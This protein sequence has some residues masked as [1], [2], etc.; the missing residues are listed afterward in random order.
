[1]AMA[2]ETE[3]RDA[4]S[5]T[6]SGIGLF[7]ESEE[8]VSRNPY[9]VH[10]WLHYLAAA[11]DSPRSTRYALYERAVAAL[12]RSY[13][14]WKLYLD[15]FLDHEA[16]GRRLDADGNEQLIALYE[17][18]L[19]QLST[20]PRL[21]LDYLAHLQQLQRVT[22]S[23]RVLDRA[24]RALP[25]TQHARVW[26][27]FVAFVR[28]IRGVPRTVR[29]VYRRYLMLEPAKREE[30]VDYLCETEQWRDA[31]TQ[32][33]VLL[34]Q[35][36]SFPT[37]KTRHA[38]WMQ[39]CDMV[40]QHP[41]DVDPS[42]D[43]D[44]LLRSG[45]AQFSDEVGRLWCALATYY[46]RL[47]L[48][49]A[50]RDVYEEAITAVL[51]VR[52]FS[53][54]FDAY[55]QFVE[56]MLTTEMELA[57][58]ERTGGDEKEQED[59]EKEEEEENHQVQVDR[60]LKIYEDVADRRPLLLNSVLLRQNPNNVREW[61]KRVTLLSADASRV[62]RTY[63]ETVQAVDPQKSGGRLATL[64]IEF[65][66]FYE[67]RQRLGD[68]RAVLQRATDVAFRN[69]QELASIH[70]AWAEMELRAENFD[71]A[72]EIVRAACRAPDARRLRGVSMQQQTA[73]DKLHRC[74]KLWTLRLDL[75]ESLGD[76]ASTRAAY[77]DAFDL[78]LIT[79]QMVLNYAAYL[80]ENKYFEESFR[81]YERGLAVFPKFP[82]ANDLW[83]AYLDKFV[84]RYGGSKVERA[85]DLHE[86]AVRAAPAESARALFT[87]Y[88]AFEEKHGMLRNVL[89]VWERA[90]DVVP[91][92]ELLDVYA[93][94]TKKAHKFMGVAKVRAIY[95][96]G[97]E[98]LPDKLVAPLCLKFAALETQL[99][100]F[101][102]AR[103]I[104][105]HAAQLCDPR[106]HE[107]S[108]WKVWHDFEVAHGSE[109]TFLEMLRI[110]R[111]VVAQY[112]T[113]NYIAEPPATESEGGAAA[114]GSAPSSAQA[115]AMAALE[116][117]VVASE[118]TAMATN[119]EGSKRSLSDADEMATRAVKAKIE[120]VTND[121]EI[122]L[123]DEDDDA[124]DV[125]ANAEFEERALPATLFG[126]VRS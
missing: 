24:L 28:G 25:V 59:A 20:M 26:A 29:A 43:V 52:D 101:E 105:A 88:A 10:A 126:S 39:L 48:F 1:M 13:K 93:V 123:D 74:I 109:H 98:R 125:A 7:P 102:R 81:V 92:S 79:P 117:D 61:Q 91:E 3:A 40:S 46:V 96:R 110:K 27:P 89:A 17:R 75:E 113:V 55:V 114:S 63:A 69:E 8:E 60:W 87:K 50:A 111:S 104:Y 54:I 68:A 14:L 62:I 38:L 82:H 115:D 16:R 64:W 53:M 107:A 94:Y 21:W 77:D 33:V 18:A 76:L 83:H 65:A 37:Q 2:S 66:K 99:G 108:F 72:L 47:G 97:I 45:I 36:R 78:Q 22:A 100:E 119:R 124:D 12:P 11:K 84:A 118:N 42:L 51:T 67:D 95:Q 106:Q 35:Q 122:D 112:S 71:E 4:F 44:A 56:A 9:S 73:K 103:A 30:Y 34:D 70:C 85:R 120:A 19:V 58:E 41:N 15:E 32:L 49:D 116:A 86:Q 121:E 31:S 23:R 80:E 57:E 6:T 5:A 90:T